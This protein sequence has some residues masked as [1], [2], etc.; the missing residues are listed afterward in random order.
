MLIGVVIANDSDNA[1]CYMLVHQAKRLQ[2]PC[3][4]VLMSFNI[5]SLSKMF[6]TN[7]PVLVPN[8]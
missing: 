6:L 5:F 2:S 4:L 7:K 3:M 8:K 1:R